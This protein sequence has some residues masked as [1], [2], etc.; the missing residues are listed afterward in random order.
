MKLCT[1]AGVGISRTSAMY[2]SFAAVP[3]LLA[4]IYMNWQLILLGSCM[5][6]A[7]ECVHRGSPVLSDG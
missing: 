4:W 1:S 3:I 7:F 2:G 5:S 6:Y